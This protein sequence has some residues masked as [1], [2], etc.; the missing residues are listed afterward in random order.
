MAN[1]KEMRSGNDLFKKKKKNKTGWG[2]RFMSKVEL[3]CVDSFWLNAAKLGWCWWA[4]SREVVVC[5]L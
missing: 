4:S 5:S 2:W 3:P 1:K